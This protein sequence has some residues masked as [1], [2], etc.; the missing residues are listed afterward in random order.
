[1]ISTIKT[2]LGVAFLSLVLAGCA[3]NPRAMSHQHFTEDGQYRAVQISM[4]TGVANTPQQTVMIVYNRV[5]PRPIAV[6]NGQTKILGEKLFDDLVKVIGTAGSAFIG[7]NYMLQAAEAKCPAGTLCG[8]LVQ[9]QNTAGA[10][11]GSTAS[12]SSGP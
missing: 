5:D 3:T 11:A 10:N 7:G 12:S 8:T 2:L 6:I 4:H 9:V 1:M